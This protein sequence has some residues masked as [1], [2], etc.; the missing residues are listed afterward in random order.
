LL[1][2]LASPPLTP[3]GNRTRKRLELATALIGCGSIKIV[4]LVATPTVDVLGIAVVGT[5]PGPWL[6]ARETIRDGLEHA[7]AVLLGWGCTE[8]PGP[9]RYYHR[10]Q[11]AWL[12]QIATHRGLARW[13]VGGTPRHPSRWQ[14]YTA[15]AFPDLPFETALASALCSSD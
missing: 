1:A 12:L 10:A 15:R 5:E 4:N 7:D 8:P 14:R 3:S 2:V 11:V 13:T 6:T 9:A